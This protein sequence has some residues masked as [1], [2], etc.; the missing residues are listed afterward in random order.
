MSPNRRIFLN[1]VATYG[2]SLYALVIGLF[3]GRWTLM[4]LG[5]DADYCLKNSST[6]YYPNEASDPF[7]PFNSTRISVEFYSW[8][9]EG[10][11][12]K[13]SQS[14]K[15]KNECWYPTLEREFAGE[16]GVDTKFWT[17]IHS[18]RVIE[19]YSAICELCKKVSEADGCNTWLNK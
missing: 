9:S 19:S 13:F 18:I 12:I 16:R 10:I 4:A 8:C 7:A 2:R 17:A 15:G 11:L 14:R 3:C 5:D 1:I 6:G